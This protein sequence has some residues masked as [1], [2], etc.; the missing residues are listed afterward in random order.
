MKEL[1]IT[2]EKGRYFLTDHIRDNVDF[3]MTA[4]S[5]GLRPPPAQKKAP[6]GYELIALPPLKECAIPAC[7]LSAAIAARRS[8]R[9]YTAQPLTLEELS[10]LLWATQGVRATLHEAAVLRTV[11]RRDAATLLKPI[12]PS[13]R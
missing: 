12:W 4:Q 6:D 2:T 7:D 3:R 8:R 5:R 1:P 9:S 10:Y 13:H 11:P